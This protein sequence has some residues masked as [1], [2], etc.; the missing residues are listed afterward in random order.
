MSRDVYLV[1]LEFGRQHEQ[2][3]IELLIPTLQRVFPDAILRGAIV[4]N[5]LADHAELAIDH[6]LHR[7]SGDN[8]MREFSG[9]DRG[10]AWVERR[11][12][13]AP[14]AIFVLA[15][16]TVVRAE[17]FER[18]RDIPVDRVEAAWRGALVGYVEA[19]PRP[20]ELFGL[21]L[22]Q[23]VDT[24]LVIAARPTLAALR[25]FARP[26]ADEELF[27]DDWRR[28][29][30]E[31]SPLSENYRAYL[32][33]WL[34]GERIDGE[35][36]HSWHAQEP[37]TESNVDASKAKLRSLLCEHLLSAR[38]RARGIPLVDIRPQPLAID[39]FERVAS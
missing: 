19:Y 9:W 16:D 30:R 5:A 2:R 12:T 28:L 35:F 1:L 23:W 32:K 13:P 34:F 7:V 3:A 10:I 21:S 38:A 15:N 17:K 37:L 26:F 20:V 25:P 18:V 4:D 8:T 29:F 36:R 6:R 33:T 27:A 11:Y 31:P 14:D 22:R 39:P 24:S